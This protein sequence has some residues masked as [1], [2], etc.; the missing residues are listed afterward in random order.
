MDHSQNWVRTHGKTTY[1]WGTAVTLLRIHEMVAPELVEMS[2]YPTYPPESQYP[3]DPPGRV[4]WPSQLVRWLFDDGEGRKGRVDAAFEALQRID[5]I[6]SRWRQACEQ[7][8]LAPLVPTPSGYYRFPPRIGQVKLGPPTT[9]TVLRRRG[10][11]LSDFEAVHDRIAAAMGVA[12]VSIRPLAGDWIVI[13]L[14]NGLAEP[15]LRVVTVA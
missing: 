14:V 15:Q 4:G 13:E 3:T 2:Q 6:K 7:T 12:K 1:R 11:L 10:Q 8:G 5:D 9:F